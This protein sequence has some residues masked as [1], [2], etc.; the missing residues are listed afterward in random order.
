[1]L[2]FP[3]AGKRVQPVARRDFQV[4]K[5]ACQVDIFEL[6][7]GAFRDV[8]R[9]ALALS[10]DVQFLRKPVCERLYH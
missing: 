4:V 9:D 5:A 2:T 6:S 8:W 1:M 3:F 10:R 7:S